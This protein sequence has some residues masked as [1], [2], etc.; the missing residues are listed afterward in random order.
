MSP[1][2]SQSNFSRRME[3][4]RWT[5]SRRSITDALAAGGDQARRVFEAMMPM[6]IDIATIEAA[7]RG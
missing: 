5:L 2:I 4:R 7:R 1:P 3:I 6:K